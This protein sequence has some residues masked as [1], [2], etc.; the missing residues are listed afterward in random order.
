[1]AP[2]LTGSCRWTCP[3][4][5]SSSTSAAEV[6]Y[7]LSRL[8]G[9]HAG[10]FVASTGQDG[11]GLPERPIPLVEAGGARR[12]LA[13]RPHALRVFGAR[14]SFLSSQLSARMGLSYFGTSGM[15]LEDASGRTPWVHTFDARIAV[16]HRGT[17][18]QRVSL[19]LEAFNLLDSQVMAHEAQGAPDEGALPVPARYQAPREVRLGVRY[20]F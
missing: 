14:E 9:N 12:T 13:D 11:Y 5:P 1:M 3:H 2:G 15:P 8:S 7:T 17:R 18:G 6:T 4:G 10:P 19:Q 16:D 20:G